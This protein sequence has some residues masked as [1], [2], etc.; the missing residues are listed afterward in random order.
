MKQTLF[1]LVAVIVVTVLFWLRSSVLREGARDEYRGWRK[2]RKTTGSWSVWSILNCFLSL[3]IVFGAGMYFLI[4]AMNTGK[5]PLIYTVLVVDVV[6]FTTLWFFLRLA[7]AN[8]DI[9][10]A[11]QSGSGRSDP[12]AL[13]RF[14]K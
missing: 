10:R 1:I 2:F 3:P 13:Q 9:R 14:L 12:S 7:A 5:V 11:Q 4:A 6:C 8:L